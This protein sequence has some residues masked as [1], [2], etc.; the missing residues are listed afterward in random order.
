MVS[1]IKQKNIVELIQKYKSELEGF[2]QLPFKTESVKNSVNAIN[3]AKN[4]HLN[5]QQ[6]T[7]FITFMRNTKIV[8]KLKDCKLDFNLAK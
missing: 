2:G 7:L 6:A 3:Q 4:Y 1:A 8:I 5:E